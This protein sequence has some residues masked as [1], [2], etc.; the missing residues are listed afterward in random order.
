MSSI[1]RSFVTF[2]N[3]QDV[4][5][6]VRIAVTITEAATWTVAGPATGTYDGS[7]RAT[8]CGTAAEFPAV[9]EAAA[10]AIPEPPSSLS[11][12]MHTKPVTATTV[13]PRTIPGIPAV[14]TDFMLIVWPRV[15]AMNGTM[16]GSCVPKKFLMSSS[17]LP[18][19]APATMGAITE[20]MV[21]HGMTARPVPTKISIVRNGPVSM[22]CTTYVPA[23]SLLP[24]TLVSARNMP[25]LVSLIATITASV[26]RPI[27]LPSN[28][29]ATASAKIV[30]VPTLATM[31]PSP[32]A[33]IL[34]AVVMV[35]FVP[36]V[37]RYIPRTVGYPTPVSACVKPPILSRSG[38]NVLITM[39][40]NSG[41]T[42]IPPGTRL[43]D[44][45]IFMTEEYPM[46][47]SAASSSFHSGRL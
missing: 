25:P 40:M 45:Y 30:A 23:S 28:I 39:P 18:R 46:R 37:N 22:L 10:P 24:M 16:I 19:I 6:G 8:A 42:I 43:M 34:G 47:W 11:V 20:T 38:K 27:M 32:R 12:T 26:L 17:R 31:I 13:T 29:L 36:T 2:L 21:S 35:I 5:S 4:K 3:H 41:T 14:A 9:L 33:R 7:A 15:K 1:S 44:L